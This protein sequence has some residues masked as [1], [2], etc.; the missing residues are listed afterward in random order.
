MSDMQ[1]IRGDCLDVLR[2]M[3]DESVDAVVTDPPYG[4]SKEPD[5]REVLTHWLAGDDYQHRG[6][7]FMG[8]TWDSFV[9]GPKV[10]EQVYRVL[11]P[12]GHVLVFAGTR[13]VD[14]MGV[15]LRLGGFETRDMLAWLYGQGFPKSMDVGKKVEGW[16]GWG[17]ALKPALEPIIMGR[18]P[19]RAG[20]K[21]ATV[22]KNVME[23]GTGAINVDAS[24]IDAGGEKLGGGAETVTTPEQKGNEGW[25]RPW[26]DDEDA[27]SAHAERVRANVKKAEGLG[28]WPA[29]VLLGHTDEC[30]QV[31]TR[32]ETVG[33]GAKMSKTGKAAVEFG[34]GYESGDGFVGS[35]IQTPVWSCTSECP[36]RLLDE[37]SGS[38][39]SRQG[40]PRAS[41]APGEGWGMKATGAEYSD[42]GGASRFFYT[43]KASK[44]ERNAGLPDG[45]KNDHPT[46]KPVALMVYLVRM[47]T[48]P[49]GLVLDPYCGSGTTGVA[50]REGGFGFIGI[51]R[52]DENKYL[53]IAKHRLGIK[54][55]GKR[56]WKKKGEK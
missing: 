15:S 29:N 22:A 31:G 7:G 30:E 6:G 44:A 35:E 37:Q 9:P 34:G 14:L 18:K 5:M 13:T 54:D 55:E 48:P 12:G 50:A 32:V 56:K 49:G 36:V 1:L 19:L 51:D 41:S 4:L 16:E 24:R 43:A 53:T 40:T 39:T 10:W 25:T 47:V 33:G 45:I 3:G 11:K 17:T 23:H 21:K 27:Q 52:D 2:G 38:S 8:K 20:G 26:M 28:R 42:T 46:V